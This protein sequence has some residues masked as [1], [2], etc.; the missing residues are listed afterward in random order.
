MSDDDA[1]R[2][3]Y[4]MC[5]ILGERARENDASKRQGGKDVGNDAD[6]YAHGVASQQP[7][8]GFGLVR[9]GWRGGGHA[10]VG[11]RVHGGTASWNAAKMH[12][13]PMPPVYGISIDSRQIG[14]SGQYYRPGPGNAWATIGYAY[15]PS[16]AREGEPALRGAPAGPE[17]IAVVGQGG[18]IP[19]GGGRD[20]GAPMRGGNRGRGHGGAFR[21]GLRRHG[22]A[23]PLPPGPGGPYGGVARPGWR[24]RLGIAPDDPADIHQREQLQGPPGN[25]RYD[26]P[27]M[28]SRNYYTASERG[29]KNARRYAH[30]VNRREAFNA[31]QAA[32]EAE[33]AKTADLQR[34]LDEAEGRGV[35]DGVASSPAATAAVGGDTNAAPDAA[36]AQDSAAASGAGVDGGTETDGVG[37]GDAVNTEAVEGTQTHASRPVNEGDDVAASWGG[38]VADAEVSNAPRAITSGTA[39]LQPVRLAAAFDEAADEA[40]GDAAVEGATG[41]VDQASKPAEPPS[42]LRS[43]RVRKP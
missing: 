9:G 43:G 30:K 27:A 10:F 4:E 21:P 8:R 13:M 29:R 42:M 5:R 12:V 6:G 17:R 15:G 11:G 41:G 33:R 22:R 31:A 16:H 26:R 28:T 34:R 25:R 40:A 37:A 20:R 24:A 1:T 3:L 18:P 36:P 39:D 32:L 23:V 7:G 38:A 35:G 2:G 14:R 19:R